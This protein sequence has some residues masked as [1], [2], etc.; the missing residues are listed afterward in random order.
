MRTTDPF[1]MM[2]PT[3][4]A[5]L[6]RTGVLLEA[7]AYES[8]KTVKPAFYDGMLMGKISRDNDSEAMLDIVFTTLQ[9]DLPIALTEVS[10]RVAEK[11]IQKGKTDFASYF[12]SVEEKVQKQI[13]K[14]VEA[15]KANVEN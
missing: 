4:N 15:Y 3:T 10:S 5:D 2:I 9:Y 12:S 13:D 7:L 1:F 6:E 11:Y 8:M 14:V